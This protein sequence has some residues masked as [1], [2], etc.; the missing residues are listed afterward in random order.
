MLAPEL[1]RKRLQLLHEA[2]PDVHRIAAL[3]VNAYSS[4]IAAGKEAA[5]LLGIE[6]F[7]VYAEMPGDYQAPSRRCA[8]PAPVRCRSFR[9]RNS[10]PMRRVWPRSP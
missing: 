7:L 10:S 5:D 2:V 4:G 1:E 3:V 8:P 9:P 6:L